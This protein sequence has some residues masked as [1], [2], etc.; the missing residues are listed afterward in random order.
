MQQAEETLADARILMDTGSEGSYRTIVNRAYY[1]AFYALLALLHT[2]GK[3]SKK[4][5]GA[6][7]L[8]DTDFMKTGIFDK[9]LSQNLHK[10][11]DL[12]M[13]DDYVSVKPVLRAE[14]EYA[15]TLS[16]EF[17][18]AIRKYLVENHFL[19]LE[20]STE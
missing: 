3:T 11:F 13:Q 19:N 6:I 4:H 1:A 9:R 15:M 5:I 20:G 14:A 2:C 10:L 17:I 16:E 12:R 7:T 18:G 8:F